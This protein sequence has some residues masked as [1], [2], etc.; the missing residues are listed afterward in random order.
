MKGLRLAS[1][2]CVA[3][4]GVMVVSTQAKALRIAPNP[5]PMRVAAADLVV[6]GKVTGFGEKL[7]PAERFKGDTGEYQIATVKVEDTLLGKG[8]KE[9]KV[10][11]VPAATAPAPGGIRI[12]S[13]LPGI[14]LMV[15][16][17]AC[18]I[19]VKH[20]TKDFYVINQYT[21]VLNKKDNPNFGAET[22]EIKKTGKLLA[23]T[24][25]GLTSKDA[26]EK[27]MTAALL[28]TKYRTPRPYTDK[29]KMTTVDPA[30]SKLILE[31]LAEA[32]WAPKV[33]RPGMNFMNPQA[34][35]YRLGATPADGWTQPKDFKDFPAE[36]KKWLKDNA[37]KFKLQKYTT[38]EPKA[39][40]P[41]PK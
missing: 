9:V 39:E 20:S 22:E 30:E 27:F 10:A 12:S 23:N 1:L 35:F 38:E 25:A 11:F 37:G 8:A 17:E 14:N 7:I 26:D 33:V 31:A 36:A 2:L 28:L 41:S 19:L 18:L 21:D 15:G 3:C 4:L 24:K 40:D 5:I 13:R 16:Q 6:V 32:D 34:M 29:P